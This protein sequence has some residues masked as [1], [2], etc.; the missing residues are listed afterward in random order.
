MYFP[1]TLAL[2][3]ISNLTHP[4]QTDQIWRNFAFTDG[5]CLFQNLMN[6][7]R[8]HLMESDRVFELPLRLWYN[9]TVICQD[10][11]VCDISLAVSVEANEDHP[12]LR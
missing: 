4:L 10:E 1:N 8:I 9:D 3:C 5:F 11:P 2:E 12:E 6:I 7:S